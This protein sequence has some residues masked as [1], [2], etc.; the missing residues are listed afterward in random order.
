MKLKQGFK[1]VS[2]GEDRF[3]IEVGGD[4]VDLR[5]AMLLNPAAEVLFNALAE[6]C[7]EKKLADILVSS[8]DVDNATAEKDVSDFVLKLKER[9]MLD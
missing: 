3:I 6:E 5:S 1:A 4:T 2:I 7:D 8:Y 9:D